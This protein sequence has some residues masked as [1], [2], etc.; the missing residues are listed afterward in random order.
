MVCS[1]FELNAAM[2]GATMPGH[3]DHAAGTPATLTLSYDFV[4]Y[5]SDADNADWTSIT[6]TLSRTLTDAELHA[7]CVLRIM[8]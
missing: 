2:D 1:S 7:L 3:L 6:H 5:R 4:R 8:A